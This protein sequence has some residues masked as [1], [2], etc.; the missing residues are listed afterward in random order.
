M[1]DILLVEDEEHLARGLKFNLEAEGYHIEV[2]GDGER[3]LE[4]L[5]NERSEFD[6]LVLDVMLPGKD[7]FTVATE[8]RKASNYIP[9]LMLTARSRPGRCAEGFC[10][11]RRRLPA[12]AL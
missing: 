7:G 9:M 8:L 11:R 10:L 5:L 12:Q 1:N 4:M 2:V 6:L 3:A